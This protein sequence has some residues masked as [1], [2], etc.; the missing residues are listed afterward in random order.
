M[1]ERQKVQKIGWSSKGKRQWTKFYIDGKEVTE[2]EY[3]GID[4]NTT[5]EDL[6]DEPFDYREFGEW[7]HKQF[8][9]RK[10]NGEVSEFENRTGFKLIG[11]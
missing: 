10:L 6:G 3:Y 5:L 11:F 7:K 4:K 1:A 8:L 2:Y 9:L